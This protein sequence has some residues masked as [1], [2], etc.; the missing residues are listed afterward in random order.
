MALNRSDLTES[1]FKCNG[2]YFEDVIPGYKTL[3]SDT[4]NLLERT[5]TMRESDSADG[6]VITRTKYPS[7]EIEIEY[8]IEGDTWD[9]FQNSYTKLMGKLNTK[10][11]TIIFNGES[12]KFVIGTFVAQSD[13]EQFQFSRSGK[14]KIVCAD[15]FKYSVMEN[16]KTAVGNQWSFTYDGT[17][18][19]HPKFEISFPETL[20]ANGN[21]TDTSECGYVGLANQN[22]SVLQ[23]GDPEEKDWGDVTHP[24]TVPIDKTFKSI[25]DWT[26]NNTGVIA[27]TQSGSI[28]VSSNHMYPSAW[29]SGSGWH[30]PSLSKIITGE[31]TPIATNFNFTWSEKFSGTK[32]QF[33]RCSTILWNNNAGTRTMV[34]AVDIIKTTKNTKCNVNL[35]VGSSKMNSFSVACSKIKSCSMKKEGN[36]VTF[37]VGGKTK[38]YSNDD[39]ENL[40]AN[41]IAFDF[42]RKGSQTVLGSNYI[43]KC[44]LQR[45]EFDSYEDIEN[46]FSPGDMLIVDTNNAEVTLDFGDGEVNAQGLGALG[47][48]WET[49]VL[50]PGTNLI[51]VDY[52][53]WTTTPPVAVM[54]YRDVYL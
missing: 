45:F 25:S 10:N 36:S 7:R 24:A 13:I 12:D 1:A 30:G 52:S 50:T 27:G 35:Y 44:K 54:K 4:R 5:V 2:E 8:F 26:L 22:G 32:K 42:G 43:S 37:S 19:S 28:S 34:C 46:V 38:S 11:A 23:F 31:A 21:N 18:V 47:N 49:F 6:S 40:V 29:G 48:D 20:D 3:N 53:D 16:S 15:P 33:G 39:I 14:Y 17:Y 9:D 41:E 51:E